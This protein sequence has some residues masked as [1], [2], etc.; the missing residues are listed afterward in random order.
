MFV[1]TQQSTILDNKT[2]IPKQAIKYIMAYASISPK[3]SAT[4]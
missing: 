2:E 3:M 4:A 1:P